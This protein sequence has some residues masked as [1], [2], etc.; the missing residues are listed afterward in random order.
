MFKVHGVNIVKNEILFPFI[1]DHEFI[2]KKDKSTFGRM[3]FNL[4]SII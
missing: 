2:Q 1:I 4:N 3:S